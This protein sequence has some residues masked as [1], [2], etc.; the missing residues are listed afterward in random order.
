MAALVPRVAEMNGRPRWRR[1]TLSRGSVM[2]AVGAPAA[3]K[4]SGVACLRIA[5]AN[6][7]RC[8]SHGKAAHL[9]DIDEQ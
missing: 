1:C 8:L 7:R 5:G 6:K 3:S 2:K 9:L 4:H